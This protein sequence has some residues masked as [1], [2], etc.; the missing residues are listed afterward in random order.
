M[1]TSL[2]ATGNILYD[3]I[4]LD[5][6]G[7]AQG[8]IYPE[9]NGKADLGSSTNRF[10]NI[11]ISGTAPTDEF[12]KGSWTP[13]FTWTTSHTTITPPTGKYVPTTQVIDAK[14][15]T[16]GNEVY[17]FCVVSASATLKPSPYFVKTNLHNLPFERHQRRRT[18]KAAFRQKAST[19]VFNY[20]NFN[21]AA[22]LDELDTGGQFIDYLFLDYRDKKT[23]TFWDGSRGEKK[24]DF[25]F[26][27]KNSESTEKTKT[28]FR[29][30]SGIY[31]KIDP[32]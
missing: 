12:T 7:L 10:D 4:T 19:N 26:Q 25:I 16:Y 29:Y 2:N 5:R 27:L 28:E 13:T 1:S 6:G 8:A 30:I 11:Y 21:P 9:E 14:Y 22:S 31:R 18:F 32:D 17:F 15:W 3:T 24:R 20:T 23:V